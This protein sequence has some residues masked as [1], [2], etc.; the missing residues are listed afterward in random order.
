MVGVL[1]KMLFGTAL[2][3][4]LGYLSMCG[5]MWYWQTSF[6]LFPR[7]GLQRTPKELGLTFEE[8]AIPSGPSQLVAWKVAPA[9]GA[10]Q[11][12][13]HCHGNGGNIDGRLE[14]A[15]ELCRRGIGVVL[16]DYRGYGRSTGAIHREGELFADAQ[17]VYDRLAQLQ[18]PIWIYGESLGGGVAAYLAEKNPCRG[19]VLQSTST[20]FTERARENYPF[21]PISRL[22]RFEMNTRARLAQLT[23]PVLVI[24]GNRDEVIGFHHGQALFAA[25]RE[26]KTWVEVEGGFHD[27][28]EDGLA[29]SVSSW[30][31]GVR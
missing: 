17:A 18:Q 23:C 9:Q 22:S 16:F 14:L 1:K 5:A 27:L 30:M 8:W 28:P 7:V 19:L 20:S 21:L 29:R 3:G 11:W 24:H 12:V 2:L 25:A 6:M 31:A 13:L 26:P 4:L 15:Q 10:N